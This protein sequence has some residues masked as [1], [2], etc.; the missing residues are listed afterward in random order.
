MSDTALLRRSLCEAALVF[1][2]AAAAAIASLEALRD[3]MLFNAALVGAGEWW[4][5]L[6][7]NFA[8]LNERHLALD[9]LAWLLIFL[10]GRTWMS[11]AAWIF[12]LV[13]GC[14]TVSA[15]LYWFASEDAFFGGLSGAL[16]GLFAV[17]ALHQLRDGERL[18]GMLLALLA[19]KLAYEGYYGS[20]GGTAT[21]IGAPVAVE[22]HLYGAAGAA[23]LF[24]LACLPAWLKRRK[25]R[26][27]GGD[28]G[29][30]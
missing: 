2:V 25:D 21:L 6:T 3:S 4:R 13:A 8:H 28:A 10:I 29:A 7:G 20:I 17:I 16:H 26:R 14:L 15:C 12:Y 11:I 27:P 1:V 18:G 5:V 30:A 19:A 22:T 23:V 9:L 24:F